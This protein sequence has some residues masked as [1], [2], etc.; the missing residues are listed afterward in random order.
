MRIGRKLCGS[1]GCHQVHFL[2]PDLPEAHDLSEEVGHSIF[3]AGSEQRGE[4]CA[5][6]GAKV[7]VPSLDVLSLSIPR[8][9]DWTLDDLDQ[10]LA[11]GLGEAASEDSPP[12]V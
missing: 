2:F 5:R 1:L 7:L 10:V 4:W 8:Y 6:C 3:I 9:E 11:R 12:M